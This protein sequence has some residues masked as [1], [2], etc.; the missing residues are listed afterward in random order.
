M[1]IHISWLNEA[2]KITLTLSINNVASFVTTDVRY[3]HHISQKGISYDT[4][5]IHLIS[6]RI[7][8]KNSSEVPSC[9]TH[10]PA[11]STNYNDTLA[12]AYKIKLH[13]KPLATKSE[14]YT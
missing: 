12:F 2:K 7:N 9:F 13:E 10:V 3:C 14:K 6:P 11:L 8:P 1:P 5:V 4:N